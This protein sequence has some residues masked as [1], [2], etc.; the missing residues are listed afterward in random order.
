M[1]GTSKKDV[2]EIE[3]TP[4][5]RVH[6]DIAQGI[7]KVYLEWMA[8]GSILGKF[9]TKSVAFGQRGLDDSGPSYPHMRLRTC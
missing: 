8:L 1:A 7:F 6:E 2:S 9:M 4:R 5:H 3:G